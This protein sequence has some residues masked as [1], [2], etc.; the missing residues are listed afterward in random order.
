MNWEQARTE[1]E[2]GNKVKLPEWTGHWFNDGKSIKVYTADCKILDSPYTQDYYDRTDWEVTDGLRDFGGAIKAL[3]A[4]KK[5]TRS[6]W[7]N[8]SIW[9][10]KQVP[11]EHSKMTKPY[12]YM[13][14]NED[15]F[16]CDLSCES[17][18]GEDWQVLN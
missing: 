3:N 10:E 4:G 7:K 12:I 2:K 1:L 5:L 16:P 9:I 6:S 11:D 13:V 8:N 14:K 18:F 17:I 15:K